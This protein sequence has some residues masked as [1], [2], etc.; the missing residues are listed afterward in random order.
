[1]AQKSM[2]IIGGGLAGLSTGVYGRLNGYDTHIFEQHTL[3]GGVCTA[4]KR[5]GY[6]MDGCI[7]WLMGSRP[8]SSMHRIYEEVGALEGNRLMILKE[9]GRC[10]DLAAEKELIFSADLDR[11]ARDMKALTS[12]PEDHTVID[13]LITAAQAFNGFDMKLDKAPELTSP[14]DNLK[15]MW[16]LRRLGK[17]VRYQK[18]QV[19]EF[20][21]QLKDPFLRWAITDVFVPE[22]PMMFLFALLGQL[23]AGDLS[24]VEGGSLKF[25]LAIAQRYKDL[26]GAITYGAEVVKILVENDRAV[27]IQLSDG[28]EHRADIVVSAADGRSTIFGMLEG[29][30]VDDKI[31]QRYDHWPIFPPLILANFGVAREFPGEVGDSNIKLHRPISI[32]GKEIDE[33]MVRI[34]NYD[35]SLAPSG[36]TTVQVML[37]HEFGYW[38]ELQKDRARY[39]AEKEKVAA[40]LLQQLE[41]LYPGIMQKVEVTDVA[42]PY[43]F[44]RY[45]RNYR[46][47]FE[48]WLMSI[49][50]QERVDKTLPG[51]ENFYMVGQWVEPGGGVPTA[52][53]SGRNL[54]QILCHQE[55]RAFKTTR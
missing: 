36:K 33:L 30:Y 16:S 47:A 14:L 38:D 54:I 48:G 6:T 41:G 19:K 55:K 12:Y 21:A 22:M 5:K 9:Y 46:G 17:Y 1:M 32:G 4:W 28:S 20:T 11:L 45:S 49:E 42:T 39:D 27:G 13:I 2:I 43:T 10:L 37:T 52:I 34:F 8:E 3:P 35:P 15:M 31:R 51:L 24:V 29:K 40:L 7:H 26:G 23:A 44:W 25:S 50:T 18:I 53:T